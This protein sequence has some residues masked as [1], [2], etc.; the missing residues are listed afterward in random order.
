MSIGPDEADRND[1][2]GSSSWSECARRERAHGLLHGWLSLRKPSRGGT[3]A[4][5]SVDAGL[6]Q[7]AEDRANEGGPDATVACRLGR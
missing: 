3:A 2:A 4:L 5:R 6:G 1:I 7:K